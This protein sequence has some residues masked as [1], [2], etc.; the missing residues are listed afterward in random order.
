MATNTPKVSVLLPSLNVRQF[1]EPRVDSLLRQTFTDWEAIVLDS[2]STDGSWEFFKAVAENDSRFR[3]HQVPREGLYAALNRGL[4]LMTGD[5]LYIAPCDDTMAPE[6]FSEMIEALGRC[7]DAGVAVCDC[8]FINQDGHELQ[9][10]DMAGRL[11]KRQI[12]NLLR[13]GSVRTS[14]PA[15]RQHRMNYRPPPHDCLLH[16]TGRS[17]YFSLTQL[18]VRTPLVKAAGFFKTDVGSA[19][20][21]GWLV[22][23]TSLTGSVHLPKRLATWRFHG[24]Q[25]S[26]SRDNTRLS[27]MNKMCQNILPVICRRYPGL[28]TDRDCALLLLPYQTLLAPSVIW[29][30][31]YWLEGVGRVL[32]MFVTKPLT[33]LRV[34]YRAGIGRNFPIAFVL[35]RKKLVPRDLDTAT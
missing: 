35:Q 1:L 7:P 14:L 18:L 34:L 21:F 17:V 5:F 2:N 16:F 31:A 15:A 8:L 27:A 26:L 25:L 23:L 19:A 10:Q 3:L 28:L 4:E 32:L 22:R 9:A 20:D 11:S 30:V 12:G 24:D 13:S 29:R 6:F 33:T